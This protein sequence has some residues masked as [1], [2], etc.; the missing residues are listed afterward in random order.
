MTLVAPRTE[1]TEAPAPR[2]MRLA[3]LAALAVPGAVLL[4][5]SAAAVSIATTHTE[6]AQAVHALL[7]AR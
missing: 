1:T 3:A 7:L 2:S 5:C 6:I 4:L